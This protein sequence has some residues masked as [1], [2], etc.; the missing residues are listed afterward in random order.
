MTDDATYIYVCQGCGRR[1]DEPDDLVKAVERK[2]VTTMGPKTE[3]RSTDSAST[4]TRPAIP[5]AR[6]ATAARRR[7]ADR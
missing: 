2:R 5:K 7:P 3:W 4:S 1:I 6:S